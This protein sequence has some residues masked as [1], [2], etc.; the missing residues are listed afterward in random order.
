MW[1]WVDPVTGRRYKKS[2]AAHLIEDI[3]DVFKANNRGELTTEQ[4]E[5]MICEQNAYP[6]PYCL[7]KKAAPF[8]TL[9]LASLTNFIT[10]VR[11]WVVGGGRLESM[12]IVEARAQVCVSGAPGGVPCPHNVAT[13]NCK[14][15]PT[16]QI[17][18]MVVDMMLSDS[19]KTTVHDKLV[20]C[21]QC[22]CRLPLKIQL[23]ASA[24]KDDNFQYPEWCWMNK[25]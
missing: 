4:V 19:R 7:G 1:Q 24:F 22:G 25:L 15:C 10:T 20:A 14:D 21:R 16:E 8:G 12:E 6:R 5:A 9:S 2:A 18:T 23:P 17:P 3:K 11:N 13:S